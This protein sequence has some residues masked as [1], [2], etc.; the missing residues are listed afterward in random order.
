MK[1]KCDHRSKF[2]NVSNWK[3]E[4]FR[5]S[6]GFEPMT[7]SIPV[8]CSTN[9][10]EALIFFRLLLSSCLNWKIYCDDHTSLSQIIFFLNI[11]S[12][13]KIFSVDI[14]MN[15]FWY[16]FNSLVVWAAMAYDLYLAV[17]SQVSSKYGCRSFIFLIS[18][19]RMSAI[20]FRFVLG[21]YRSP[22]RAPGRY[23]TR[24]T[25]SLGFVA[26]KSK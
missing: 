4:A 7:S 13:S 25:T 26:G 18:T 12:I 20:F 9:W 23:K 14:L 3:E 22:L 24:L 21:R 11:L 10:A 8:R 15:K 17:W 6:T 16:L 1:V 2:S 5:A 19:L